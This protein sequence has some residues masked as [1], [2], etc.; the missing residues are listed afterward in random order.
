MILSHHSCLLHSWPR[1]MIVQG[2]KH[3]Q[4]ELLGWKLRIHKGSETPKAVC[5]NVSEI[6]CVDTRHVT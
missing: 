4:L 6:M 3:S 5:M 1:H 2:T